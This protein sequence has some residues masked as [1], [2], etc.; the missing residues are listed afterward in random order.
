MATYAYESRRQRRQRQIAE[1]QAASQR[2]APYVAR[3]DYSGARAALVD[4]DDPGIAEAIALLQ[5]RRARREAPPPVREQPAPADAAEEPKKSGGFLRKALRAVDRVTP[6]F[7]ESAAEKGLGAALTAKPAAAAAY[8]AL[9][10][11]REYVGGPLF[12]VITGTTGNETKIDPK[13]GKPYRDAPGF[14]DFGR[15]LVEAATRNPLDTYAEARVATRERMADPNLGAGSRF[16][17]STTTD[18]LTYVGPGLLK[19]AG[20]AVPGALASARGSKGIATAARLLLENPRQ[21]AGG[22]I[23]GGALA[24]E[25]TEQV[26]G[27]E[28]AGSAATLLGAIAGGGL[29]ARTA[30]RNAPPG[31]PSPPSGVAAP[32]SSSG[33]TPDYSQGDIFTLPPLRVTP[34]SRPQEALNSVKHVIFGRDAVLTDEIAYPAMEARERLKP[35]IESQGNRFATVATS[36]SRKTFQ[37]DERE[38][39]TDI[40]GN[41]TLQDLAARLPDYEPLMTPTQVAA[42]RRIEAEVAPFK[43]LLD[44]AGV[45]VGNRTD[46]MEGGFYLPRGRAEL[47]GTDEP[48]KLFGGK[49]KPGFQKTATFD[50]MSDGINAG[51]EYSKFEEAMA[52]Y[53]RAAGRASVD[54]HVADYFKSVTDDAGDLIATTPSDR[55]NPRI[56]GMWQ[57]ATG[58]LAKLRG[59]LATAEK[60]AAIASKQQDEVDR[61]IGE[62]GRAVPADQGA[63]KVATLPT[64]VA[65]ETKRGERLAANAEA[66]R[67]DKPRR[68][69]TAGGPVRIATPATDAELA[70]AQ[71][72]DARAEEVARVVGAIDEAIPADIDRLR[73]LDTA[74]NRT[75]R[76]LAALRARGGAHAA[77]A[78]SLSADMARLKAAIEG[79]RPEYKAALTRSRQTPRGAS[80]IDLLG[81]QG[82][83]FPTAMA[84]VAN[85]YVLAER[86]ATGFGAG[87]VTLVRSLNGLLRGIK[88]T[89]DVSFMGIQ[90]AIGAASDPVGFAR[91]LRVAYQ[92]MADPTVLGRYIQQFDEK[93]LAAG[94]PTS[95]VWASK[96]LR[97]GGT[98]TEFEIGQG[99]GHIGDALLTGNIPKT[100][101][102]PLRGSNRAFGNFG[103]AM[104]L[105][106]ANVGYGSARLAKFDMNDPANL[107]SV[108]K[109]VNAATGWSR[110]RFAGDVGEM[111][112]FAPRF[113][114]SQLEFLTTIATGKGPGAM[115]AR[116]MMLQFLGIGIGLTTVANIANGEGGIPL[117]EQFDLG[118]PN[119][120]RFRANGTDVSLFG[121][122]DSLVRGITRTVQDGDPRAFYRSKS[123]PIVSNAWTALSGS[124]FQGQPV[125]M[126]SF[127]RDLVAPF[128]LSDSELVGGEKGLGGTALGLTGTKAT[129]MTPREELDALARAKFN[130]TF[131]DLSPSEQKGMK[132]AHPEVWERAVD[133]KTKVSQQWEATKQEAVAEQ[134]ARDARLLAGELTVQQWTDARRTALAEKA[135]AFKTLYGDKNFE[136]KDKVLE[137]YF[138]AMDAATQDGVL[139]FELVDSYM[140]GLSE[141]DRAHITANTGVDQTPI[142]KLRKRLASEYYALPQYRGYSADEGREIN[143]LLIEVS[144]TSRRDDD[145][146]KLKAL[147]QVL[148]EGTWSAA[149]AKGARRSIL[150]MLR[151]RRDR[152]RFAR[153][154]PEIVI[155]TGR[156]RLAATMA[157]AISA[158]AD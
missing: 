95:R 134:Q 34:L 33:L 103:D 110:K 43:R 127:L 53:G 83:S 17:L 15:G 26:T 48:M 27:S 30:L 121:P 69:M 128:S 96:G 44:E 153:A 84:N 154:H 72:Y 87:G 4:S 104:R 65:N 94:R 146:A 58:E 100:K 13:T 152:E 28:G 47:E 92:S 22:A 120:M 106:M 139:D 41:P 78:D 45:E 119:F 50:S 117:E 55:M 68:K 149:A 145:L 31:M 61:A 73:F 49:G 71:I 97:I 46:V 150:G 148:A 123:S 8:K 32:P 144:N 90:G 2:A 155:L 158:A 23:V 112:L 138:D 86:P 38:R 126:G 75:E 124:N 1:L 99:L 115:E 14:R 151:E 135:G 37:F 122:W 64:K 142:E 156:G 105:E 118:G 108:A 9:D 25:A 59:R 5:E 116:R 98:Q 77:T 39:I 20:K 113:F 81:L 137:G 62:F 143:A 114:N 80:A 35:V 24:G 7:V 60:R 57:D 93:A 19:A 89:A 147:R 12:S 56:R 131:Y 140:E 52:S 10:Y 91:A 6:E 102:N 157:A 40:P 136:R 79:L 132:D 3:G 111:A 101:L 76:R 74:M 85:K 63:R 141:T 82:Y 125:S 66:Q 130:K 21:A 54:K 51:Y 109:A 11:G 107:E 16:L 29:A 67:A 36:I 18:P 42:M 129:A 88:A 70:R 133:R